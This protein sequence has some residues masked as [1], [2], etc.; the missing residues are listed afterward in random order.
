MKR[1]KNDVF[2][3]F[4]TKYIEPKYFYSRNNKLYKAF[5]MTKCERDLTDFE[6]F[7][8]NSWDLFQEIL[9]EHNCFTQQIGRTSNFYVTNKEIDNSVFSEFYGYNMNIEYYRKR[10]DDLDEFNDIT[11]F[12]LLDA[13]YL[14]DDTIFE[15]E[16]YFVSNYNRKKIENGNY[17]QNEEE[18]INKYLND[19]TYICSEII[20]IDYKAKLD[21]VLKDVVEVINWIDD[22]KE[23]QERLF[24]EFQEFID[25]SFEI[26]H[27][28]QKNSECE[29]LII[30]FGNL[31]LN[32]TIQRKDYH[33]L[34]IF[35]DGVSSL[36]DMRLKI[37]KLISM[38]KDYED[39]IE[40]CDERFI[41]FRELNI[42]DFH[43]LTEF[44]TDLQLR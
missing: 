15:N 39:F 22:F 1:L 21:E 29:D 10:K 18:D 6:Y 34:Q 3:Y 37:N 36:Y 12:E 27:E 33:T 14:C 30:I 9:K 11:L 13:D 8:E 43:D 41:E 28:E 4:I 31:S 40:K 23:D 32:N 26:D 19:I 24:S 5:Y 44:G 38:S 35:G 2:E 42:Q 25:E 20:N 16:E 7:C 17:P